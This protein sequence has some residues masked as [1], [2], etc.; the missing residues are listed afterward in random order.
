MNKIIIPI[1]VQG[2]SKQRKRQAPKGRRVDPQA[3]SEVQALLGDMP[4]RRDLL[5]ECLHLI[6]DQYR[7]LSTPHLAALA[8]ELRMAQTEVYEVASFYHH[9]DIVREGQDS[10]AALTVRVCDGIACELAGAGELLERLPAILG[11]DVRVLAAPCVGRC[12]QA[13]VAVV[14]QKPIAQAQCETVQAAVQAG[15]ISDAPVAGYLD[16][17][18]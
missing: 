11:A 13:P 16:H 12:E 15:D 4:R 18:G 1:A 9:F 7:C 8:Q 5:I 14:G 3:L 2:A 6:Q 17:A 10:P